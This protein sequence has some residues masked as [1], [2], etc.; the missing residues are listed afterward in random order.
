MT[1]SYGTKIL[2]DNEAAVYITGPDGKIIGHTGIAKFCKTAEEANAVTQANAD[3]AKRIAA[4]LNACEGFDTSVLE[5]HNWHD[6]AYAAEVREFELTTQR[7]ELLAALEGVVN[8][9]TR[10][11]EAWD[12]AFAAIAKA[13]APQPDPEPQPWTTA[14]RHKELRLTAKAAEAERDELLVAL[15]NLL[16]DEEWCEGGGWVYAKNF[17]SAEAARAAIANAKAAQS[18]EPPKTLEE[19][20]ALGEKLSSERPAA[21]WA[22]TVFDARE[23]K[24]TTPRYTSISK[25]GSYE[26]LGVI[27]GAGKLKGFAGIGYRDPV[28]GDLFI[29]EPE[30]FASRMQLVKAGGSQ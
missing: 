15:E 12:V 6:S 8:M 14:A 28:T 27:R 2:D 29:R 19:L 5:Q 10:N 13:K 22:K 11:P 21:G 23:A 4:C 1:S 30:C 17:S 24:K 9:S 18:A 20:I 7:N 3:M 26:K 16:E 25:G